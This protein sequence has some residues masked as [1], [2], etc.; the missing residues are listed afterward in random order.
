M[1]TERPEYSADSIESG[2]VWGCEEVA[3]QVT[4]HQEGQGKQ[5]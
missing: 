5:T 4:A 3:C 1:W 2:V